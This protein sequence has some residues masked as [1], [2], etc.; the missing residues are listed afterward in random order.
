[1]Q[2][3]LAV[4]IDRRSFSLH[5]LEL[6]RSRPRLQVMAFLMKRGQEKILA[7]FYHMPVLLLDLSLQ[8]N[9]NHKPVQR[10]RFEQS[11]R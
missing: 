2:R 5:W 3:R 8:Q 9:C 6:V 7:P 10:Q 4:Q 11:Q 1:V